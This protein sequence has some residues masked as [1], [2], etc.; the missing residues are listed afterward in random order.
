M[1]FAW[2][3]AVSVIARSTCRSAR[4]DPA[5][6]RASGRPSAST[7]K[8]YDS[9]SSGNDAASHELQTTPPAAAEKAQVVLLTNESSSSSL[10]YFTSWS[11]R[12]SLT[13]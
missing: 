12:S 8:P 6:A 10:A 3:S 7:R 4:S 11:N 9:S 1:T 2:C 5:G 13:S